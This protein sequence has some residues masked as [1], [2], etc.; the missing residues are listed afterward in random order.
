MDHLIK[1]HYHKY[2][3]CTS[4]L[5]IERTS[6][7]EPRVKGQ[8]TF[9]VLGCSD[10]GYHTHCLGWTC[11]EVEVWVYWWAKAGLMVRLILKFLAH[12]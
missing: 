9:W 1:L 8:A 3:E 10:H 6:N 12:I 7:L 11:E 5:H 2:W 4:L